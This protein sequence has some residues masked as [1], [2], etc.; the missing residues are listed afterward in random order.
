MLKNENFIVRPN[1][2]IQK[3]SLH[4][5]IEGTLDHDAQIQHIM[6]LSIV[7]LSVEVIAYAVML[8]RDQMHRVAIEAENLVDLCGTGGDQS[9]SFNISTTASFV[10]AG[11]GVPVAKHGNISI[12]SKSGSIDVLK[13]LDVLIPETPQDAKRQFEQAG[14]CFL[15]APYFHPCFAQFAAARKKLAAQGKKTIFNILGPLLNPAGVRRA[16]FGVFCA[17]FVEPLAH[18]MLQ[19]GTQKALVF[20]GNGLDELSLAGRNTIAEINQGI[21]TTYTKIADDFGFSP[22][23]LQDLKGGTP[24]ENAEIIRSILR[25]SEQG[26]KTNMVILNAAAAIYAALDHISF[27]DAIAKAKESLISGAANRALE[28]CQS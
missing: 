17:D 21:I 11:A 6:N 7:H 23:I 22:C 16:A 20:C 4:H 15:F 25:V 27:S 13:A 26:P 10:V 5:L 9:E 1:D 28:T 3:E 8:F 19:T 18:V 12:T 24:Q 14:I 2:Q